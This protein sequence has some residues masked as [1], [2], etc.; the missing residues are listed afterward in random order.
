MKDS[1]YSR[2]NQKAEPYDKQTFQEE[3]DVG[4]H[5]VKDFKIAVRAL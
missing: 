4:A 1:M 2:L 3:H 5:N